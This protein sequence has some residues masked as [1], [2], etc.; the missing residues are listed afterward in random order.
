MGNRTSREAPPP[1]GAT[2]GPQASACPVPEAY[3]NPAVYNVYNQRIN[4]PGAG[5]AQGSGPGLEGADILD[6][7]N[8][9][10][11]EPNQQPCPGQKKLLSTDRVPSNIPKGGTAAT[12]VYPSP[13]MFYNGE[14][15]GRRRR[16]RGAFY[17]CALHLAVA[18]QSFHR[19][20]S[21][22]ILAN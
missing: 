10:P 13:Q 15:C 22:S 19:G 21:Q 17:F 20:V 14:R 7:K 8:N 2:P 3:R 4:D 12:W 9:M 6:P 5:T 18:L 16:G 11:L 1:A